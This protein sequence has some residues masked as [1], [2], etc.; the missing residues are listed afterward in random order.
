MAKK[1]TIKNGDSHINIFEEQK[2]VRKSA[3]DVLELAKSQEKEKFEK[4]YSYHSLDSKTK[5]LI[6]KS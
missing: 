6:K 2:R 1:E 4:G 5:I 3:L